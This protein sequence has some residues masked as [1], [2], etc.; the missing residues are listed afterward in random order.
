MK[1]TID[2]ELTPDEIDVILG[3]LGEQPYIKVSEVITKIRNQAIP[4]WQEISGEKPQE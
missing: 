2:L 4:Q 1:T 3:S